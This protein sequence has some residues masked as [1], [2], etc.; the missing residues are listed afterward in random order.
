MELKKDKKSILEERSDSLQE[1]NNGLLQ[2]HGKIG[3]V[4]VFFWFAPKLGELE[5]T[6]SNFPEPLYWICTE[7]EFNELNRSNNQLVNNIDKI[8]I[9]NEKSAMDTQ[10]SNA[11]SVIEGFRELKEQISSKGILLIT[12]SAAMLGQR[13]KEIEDFLSMY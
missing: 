6:L 9:L 8:I 12:C 2:A 5:N 13:K 7:D 4:D 10:I 3:N 11:D 1:M